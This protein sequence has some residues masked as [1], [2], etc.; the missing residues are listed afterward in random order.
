MTRDDVEPFKQLFVVMA[1]RMAVPE[2]KLSG[3]G[4]Y[5]LAFQE[6]DPAIPFECVTINSVKVTTEVCSTFTCVCL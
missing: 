6:E 5:F 2:E 1:Q 4:S 3:A